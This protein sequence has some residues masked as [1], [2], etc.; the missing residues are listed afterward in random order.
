M[1]SSKNVPLS[2]NASKAPAKRVPKPTT[3][4]N[5]PVSKTAIVRKTKTSTS[6]TTIEQR[7]HLYSTVVSQPST[8]RHKTQADKEFVV[9]NFCDTQSSN[10]S[11]A[12]KSPSSA[13]SRV[14]PD[15]TNP[16]TPQSPQDTHT[17]A[18]YIHFDPKTWKDETAVLVALNSEFPFLTYNIKGKLGQ[19]LTI[20]VPNV[21]QF[22]VFASLKQLKNKPISYVPKQPFTPSIQSVIFNV[23]ATVSARS[24]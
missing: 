13:P 16:N 6:A 1:K 15:T 4:F 11:P 14:V 7:T 10:P 17:N 5:P 18:F 20:I 8:S 22:T 19:S 3:T 23:P 9:Q 21:E 24:F 12:P 2:S